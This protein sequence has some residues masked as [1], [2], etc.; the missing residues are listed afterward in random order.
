MQ[1]R[2]VENLEGKMPRILYLL[3][4]WKNSFEFVHSM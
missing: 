4:K 1:F 2:A 3:L